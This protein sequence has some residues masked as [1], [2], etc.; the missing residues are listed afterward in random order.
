MGNIKF[1]LDMAHRATLKRNDKLMVGNVDTTEPNYIDIAELLSVLTTD[2]LPESDTKKYV[3]PQEK[4]KLADIAEGLLTATA[5][6]ELFYPKDANPAGYLTSASALASAKLTGVIA[7]SLIPGLNASKITEGILAAARIPDLSADKITSGTF[8]AAR[9]PNLS[10]DKIDGLSLELGKY[11]LAISMGKAGGPVAL[12][13]NIK[14]PVGNIPA[15]DANKITSGIL[16]E[17]RI[18]SNFLKVTQLVNS[19]TSEATNLP[20]AANAVRLLKEYVDNLIAGI[21]LKVDALC[22]TTGNIVLQGEQVIDGV[23]TDLSRVLVRAQNNPAENGI[24]QT[25]PAGWT[26][27]E[28]ANTV[29]DINAAT[30]MVAQGN[31]LGGLK[32]IGSAEG[33]LEVD[34]VTWEE[35]KQ[36]TQEFVIAEDQK[37]LQAAKDYADAAAKGTQVFEVYKENAAGEWAITQDANGKANP[38]S[39]V[40]VFEGAK[41]L[42][43]TNVGLYESSD[44]NSDRIRFQPQ[45]IIPVAVNYKVLV[46]Y[47]IKNKAGGGKSHT[48]AVY[49]ERH[50]GPAFVWGKV[51]PGYD[52]LS[53]EWQ[54]IT[55]EFDAGVFSNIQSLSIWAEEAG[56]SAYIDN[57]TISVEAT[58]NYASKKY[59]DD[60]DAATLQAAKDHGN[61]TYEQKLPE[62]DGSEKTLVIQPDGTKVWA[63]EKY[64]LA[65]KNKLSSIDAAHYGQPLQSL[66]ELSAIPE[67]EASDKERRYVEDELS[68]YFY[69]ANLA[70]AGENTVAPNDQTNGTG[71]W[72]KVSVGGDTAASIKTKYE[73]NPDT[74]AFTDALLNK[75]N[76]ITAIFTT[77]LKNSYDTAASWVSTN[78][79]NVLDH[80]TK[81]A[82]PATAGKMPRTLAD[83]SIE[84]IDEPSGSGGTVDTSNLAKLDQ[85]NTFSQS[86][87]INDTDSQIQLTLGT[88]VENGGRGLVF[89]KGTVSNP[90]NWIIR[91][92]SNS[93]SSG[94][95]GEI[96]FQIRRR[97]SNNY[98]TLL[99]VHPNGG[100]TGQVHVLGDFK[101]DGETILSS[102]QLPTLTLKPNSQVEPFKI[103][104]SSGSYM[105]VTHRITGA[106]GVNRYLDIV[107]QTNSNGNGWG[108]GVR[109]VGINGQDGE[110]VLATFF[111]DFTSG[112]STVKNTLYGKTTLE[113]I[114][115]A[116]LVEAADDAAAAAAGVE[117]GYAYVNSAT[118]A[119]HKRMS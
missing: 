81:W 102:L 19:M 87:V 70:V 78:G 97:Y 118:G 12:D 85:Q 99:K 26:R 46:K 43:L 65:E 45:D 13:E 109:L 76:S 75:L 32:F 111:H 112:V 3:T 115:L 42:E 49:G 20:A 54:E 60:G 80:L 107:A 24:Y 77:A 110:Q 117:V 94:W 73:S 67:A 91:A 35:V 98:Y 17:E 72:R 31:T 113:E 106:G 59:V 83:G 90:Q 82:T 38:D 69:D 103:S 68:D 96:W 52:P 11:V 63:G 64:S 79:Q 61:A 116:N 4:Q 9:I 89:E 119:V 21:K 74:N 47:H 33:E 88:N 48:I 53:E 36:V 30:V 15:L 2:D 86:Q 92:N 93:A 56:L 114:N 55:V 51:P 1:W 37:T 8:D 41:S 25:D 27:T 14:V 23:Q 95:M 57:L 18:P 16:A 29:E 66:A 22:A 50:E 62:G 39:A 34:P 6:A 7:A 101:V 5:A 40:T 104:D 58:S 10:P 100:D 44:P 105:G 108:A 84:W 71:F 28:D